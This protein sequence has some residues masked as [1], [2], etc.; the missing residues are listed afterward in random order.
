M[1]RVKYTA[2]DKAILLQFEA[3]SAP[4]RAY[5]KFLQDRRDS[6]CYLLYESRF[7]IQTTSAETFAMHPDISHRRTTRDLRK[8]GEKSILVKSSKAFVDDDQEMEYL[9]VIDMETPVEDYRELFSTDISNRLCLSERRLP[10][11]LAIPTLLNPMFGQRKVIVGSDLM[12]DPQY[13]K[14]RNRLLQMM[15]DILDR[16]HPIAVEV[17]AD[18]EPDSEDDDD[19]GEQVNSNYN[20]AGEELQLFESYKKKKYRPKLSK[21]KSKMLENI[22]VPDDENDGHGVSNFQLLVGPVETRGAD[23]PSKLNLADYINELGRF[24]LLP[25]FLAHKHI[26]P[27]LWVVA[28]RADSY[29]VVEV[30]CERFF[31][32]SGYISSPQR[33]RLGVRNYE[34]LAMLASLIRNVYINEEWVAQEYLRRC[35]AGAWKPENTAEALKC[36][37]LER[38]IEAKMLQMPE[39][40]EITMTQFTSEQDE[41]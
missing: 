26:F 9:S 36:W 8:R 37:N 33:T 7:V 27:T 14:S 18:S 12:S 19:V 5:S 34:R 35:K 3:A 32:L 24:R 39:P 29:R 30:G 41:D 23:L 15:Q 40:D 21:D 25:F 10:D 17:D 22:V 13:N 28:Q 20:R 6:V 31:N 16:K 38:I 2:N 11:A 1:N 4:V